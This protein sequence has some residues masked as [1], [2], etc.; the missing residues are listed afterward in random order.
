MVH[1]TLRS[2]RARCASS[3]AQVSI[4]ETTCNVALAPGS[5]CHITFQYLPVD[6]NG[7]GGTITVTDGTSSIVIPMV[8]SG[9]EPYPSEIDAG[10]L[11]GGSNVDSTG[12]IF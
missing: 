6:T 2:A 1:Q 8:G 3:V 12:A 9:R 10:A 11:D 4:V 7:V 5:S